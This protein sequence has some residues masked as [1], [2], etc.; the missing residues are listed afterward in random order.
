MG[1]GL[2]SKPMEGGETVIDP[3]SQGRMISFSMDK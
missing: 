2:N 1:A 3:N